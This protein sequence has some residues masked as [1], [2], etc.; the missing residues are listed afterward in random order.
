MYGMTDKV[1]KVNIDDQ[2]AQPEP[3]DWMSYRHMRPKAV[4]EDGSTYE[5]KGPFYQCQRCDEYTVH[6]SNDRVCQ[7]KHCKSNN[8][9]KSYADQYKGKQCRD[10]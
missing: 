6:K 4:R 9:K 10:C 7:N 5:M 8:K 1:I 3:E 2:E